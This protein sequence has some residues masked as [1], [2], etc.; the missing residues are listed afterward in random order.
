MKPYAPNSDFLGRGWAFPP[1][2]DRRAGEVAMV[3]D[4]EDIRQSLEVLF[5]TLRGERVMLPLYGCGLQ[6]FV[7]DAMGPALYTR[8][9]SELSNAIL[10]YEPRIDVERIAVEPLR[11]L[12]GWLTITIVYTIRQTNTRSNMVFP[13][14]L[15][16]EGTHVRQI[17]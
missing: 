17:G 8:I 7:F 13:F 9:R 1:S 3:Q 12:E 4:D 14:Y 5:T 15:A 11:P 10:Y 6:R 16:G 2:F